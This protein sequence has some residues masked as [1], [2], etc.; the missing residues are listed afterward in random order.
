[1]PSLKDIDSPRDNEPLSP[2][3]I[4]QQVTESGYSEKVQERI[5]VC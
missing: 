5:K 1:M 3:E 4:R 2:S